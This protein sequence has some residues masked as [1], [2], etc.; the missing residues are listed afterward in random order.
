MHDDA[1][2]NRVP[3]ALVE[4]Q[5]VDAI[6][7]QRSLTMGA[8]AAG[9]RVHTLPDSPRDVQ[10][11]GEFHYAV[12]GPSAASESGKPSAEAR[13]F[14]DETTGPDRP[15]ANRNAVVLAVPSR[16]GLDAA[17]ARIREHLGWLEV[18]EQLKG[19]LIDPVREQ[20]L[21]NETEL[22]R[23][24]V[25]DVVGQAYSIVVT[26]NESNEVQAFRI[27]VG[28]DPLFTLIKADRRSRIQETAISS[29]AMMPGGPYD[30]WAEGE[31]SRRVKDLVSAFARFP[32]LPKMLRRREV[33]NTIGQG[34]LSGILVARLVRPDRTTKTYW[35]T[36]VEQHV[37]E[38]PDLEVLLPEAATLSDVDHTL[39]VYGSLPE[40]WPAKEITVENVHEYFSGEHTVTVPREG[41]DDTFFIPG[42]DSLHVDEAIA[43]AVEQ[44][45]L[46]MTNGPA[47]ILGE[48]V[49]PGI[50]SPPA[51]LRPPPDPIA[52]DELMPSSIP[53]A[54]SEEKTNALAIATALSTKRGVTLPW[55][56]VQTAVESAIRTRWLELSNDS[57]PW[58][59]NLAGAQ[60]VVLQAPTPGMIRDS[61]GS[62]YTQRPMGMFVAEGSL[63]AH[64]I[65]DLADHIP[66][67]AQAAAGS[68]LSFNIRIELGDDTAPDQSVVD[69][70]NALLSEVSDDLKLT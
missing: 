6:E 44:G 40:L 63:E 46:W 47:S 57:A 5:L 55:F 25:P 58:P 11:D 41:Y 29:E 12:L 37:L 20:M 52:V 16:D 9:A 53:E 1:C 56:S 18:R 34:V 32:K 67:I 31:T 60:H 62:R 54:W 13:R 3:P 24:R 65:Q 26:L 69:K 59:S 15:R 64:G 66:E 19:Q 50:L 8:A 38:D 27:T 14:I 39:L 17:R 49:P 42:C 61:K 35:R 45:L 21:V 70:I 48:P 30:L 28:A 23:K 68:A 7:K 36:A 43:D 10:D 2:A 22:A 4:S 51:K 33:L